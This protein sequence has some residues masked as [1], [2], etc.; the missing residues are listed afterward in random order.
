MQRKTPLWPE[1][2][3][4]GSLVTP[5][6][7]ASP[8]GSHARNPQTLSYAAS[9]SLSVRGGPLVAQPAPQAANTL[10]HRSEGE[11]GPRA[12]RW[13]PTKMPTRVPE[14]TFRRGSIREERAAPAQGHAG[15]TLIWRLR[16][17]CLLLGQ[18]QAPNNGPQ[19]TLPTLQPHLPGKTIE[20]AP[21]QTPGVCRT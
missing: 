12:S 1:P 8:Q 5:N 16:G 2:P 11:K 21:S 18:G 4:P 13:E 3:P 9:V 17:S 19:D 15:S 14:R 6:H 10:C 20:G 7:L